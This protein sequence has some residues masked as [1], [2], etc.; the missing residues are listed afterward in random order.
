MGSHTVT[1]FGVLIKYVCN[2]IEVFEHIN[3]PQ[4]TEQT[5]I[6]YQ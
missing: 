4:N 3:V 5:I 1:W 2:K 6:V